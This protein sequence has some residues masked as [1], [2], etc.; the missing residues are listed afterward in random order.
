MFVCLC[1]FVLVCLCSCSLVFIL[2]LVPFQAGYDVFNALDLMD[3]KT[4][5]EDLK[6]GIGDGNLHYYLFNWKCPELKPEQVCDL[7]FD[8][9][10]NLVTNY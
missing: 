6:F 5:L 7:L 2:P 8:R 1:L 3:N 4:F 9:F 10:A